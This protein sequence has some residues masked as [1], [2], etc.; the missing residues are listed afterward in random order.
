MGQGA[1]TGSRLGPRAL[2]RSRKGAAL[3]GDPVPHVETNGAT[4]AYRTSG[5]GPALLAPECN[6][7]WTPEVEESMAQHFTLVVATP[8]DFG[9]SSRPGAPYDPG[10]WVSDM[11]TV[12]RHLGHE[13]F[14]VFGYSFTGAFGPW[15]A[16]ELA[17]QDVVTAVVSGGFPL[18]GDYGIV[19]RGVDDQ[20]AAMQQD[21]DLWAAVGERFDP[22]A[23]AAFY[24]QLATLPPD[25]LVDRAPCPLYCFW[26]DRDDDAVGTVIPHAELADGLSRRG[27]TW[28]QY[29]GMDHEALNADLAVAWPDAEKWL[30][31]HSIPTR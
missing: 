8:R 29:A 9:A 15:L 26:G 6:Y 16:L 13:S 25:A 24:R 30:L 2:D 11:L 12:M 5:V 20:M 1:A 27:V 19:S 28:K 23:A 21:E 14:A 4:L 17:Q 31:A 7:T 10:L 18:L 22:R 3:Y